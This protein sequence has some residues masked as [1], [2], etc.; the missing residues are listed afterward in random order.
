M[1][2]GSGS[3]TSSTPRTRNY[4]SQTRPG[5]GLFKESG[6]DQKSL[7]FVRVPTVLVGLLP[8]PLAIFTPNVLA[9]T[10]LAKSLWTSCRE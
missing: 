8:I 9:V 1:P 6:D 4:A 7:T 10:F 5:L 2:T 3:R